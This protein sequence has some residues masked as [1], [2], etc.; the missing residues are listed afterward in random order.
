MNDPVILG[1]LIACAAL[2][3][4]ALVF[5]AIRRRREARAER[6]RLE[7]RRQQI[8]YLHM[9]QQEVERMASRIIATSSTSSLAGFEVVR[10]IEAV[11][12]DGAP[13]P[14]RAVDVLKAMAAE[15]GANAIVNLASERQPSGKCSA[16]GDA[17]IAQAAGEIRK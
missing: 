9:Q 16:R 17:V 12:T 15:K 11:F 3:V 6:Q 2:L 5:T 10:Q 13:S 4:F 14:K 8:G 7:S 1:L